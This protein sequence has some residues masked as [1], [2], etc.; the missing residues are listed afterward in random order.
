MKKYLLALFA[1]AATLAFAACREDDRGGALVLRVSESLG[2]A[3]RTTEAGR[4]F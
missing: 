1:I 3:A 2:P 4:L